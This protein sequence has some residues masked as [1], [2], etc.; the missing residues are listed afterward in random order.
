MNLV[1]KAGHNSLL[2][3]ALGQTRAED[4][5]GGMRRDVV[6]LSCLRGAHTRFGVAEEYL[7]S[8]SALKTASNPAVGHLPEF[9]SSTSWIFMWLRAAGHVS[10]DGRVWEQLTRR[11]A[12]LGSQQRSASWGHVTVSFI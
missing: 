2:Q 5:R 12:V 6:V 9:L 11:G 10:Q 3:P 4:R 7:S 8:T 1:A